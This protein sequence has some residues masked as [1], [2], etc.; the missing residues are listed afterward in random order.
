MR[1]ALL[2]AYIFLAVSSVSPDAASE[3]FAVPL[4]DSPR[5]GPEDAPVTIVEFLDFQ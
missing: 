1:L 4:G 3:R 2:T 5:F